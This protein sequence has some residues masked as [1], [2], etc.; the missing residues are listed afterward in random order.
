[1]D[2]ERNGD[3]FVSERG[4][5][6]TCSPAARGEGGAATARVRMQFSSHRPG[7]LFILACP[8]TAYTFDICLFLIIL[9]IM[10]LPPLKVFHCPLNLSESKTTR[11]LNLANKTKID[12]HPQT[13]CVLKFQTA[14]NGF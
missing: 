14:N 12:R 11:Y 3:A 10:P 5:R 2:L 6:C 4:Q 9:E 7:A 13:L 1:M 8:V